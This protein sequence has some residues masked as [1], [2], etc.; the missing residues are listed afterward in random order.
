MDSIGA[1]QVAERVGGFTLLRRHVETVLEGA[2]DETPEEKREMLKLYD[3]SLDVL[4][5]YLKNPVT[6]QRNADS[7]ASSSPQRGWGWPDVPT[8]VRYAANQLGALLGYR[9][10]VDPL[11]GEDNPPPSVDLSNVQ[12]WD[13]KWPGVDFSWLTTLYAPGI[14]LRG[15]NLEQTTWGKQSTLS[16]GYLQC[17][18]LSGARFKGAWVEETDFRGAGLPGADFRKAHL[19]KA[20]FRDADLAGVDFAG[21]D[22]THAHFEGANLKGTKLSAANTKGASGLPPDVDRL[23]GSYMKQTRTPGLEEC[24]A[25]ESYWAS[26][27]DGTHEDLSRQLEELEVPDSL[28]MVEERYTERCAAVCP[29]LERW[30]EVKGSLSR[31]TRSLF[32]KVRDKSEIIEPK[33]ADGLLTMQR[34]DYLYSITFGSRADKAA[35]PA[36]VDVN[37]SVSPLENL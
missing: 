21:A 5:I 23:D 27:E 15:A 7:S 2:S 13:Q 16:R 6:P 20:D 19:K 26:V 35:V 32:S 14:D 18:S 17:A 10:V 12:L 34:G 29:A 28:V 24:K 37:I 33:G 25:D 9:G 1:D 31:A 8:D 30:F 11:A 22:V 4:E 36:Y 3:T